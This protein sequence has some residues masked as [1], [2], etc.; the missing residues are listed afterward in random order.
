MLRSYLL[1]FVFA[2]A[3][4]AAP[5]SAQGWVNR[6]GPNSPAPRLSHAMCYDPV[7]GYVLMVG[8]KT[9]SPFSQWAGETWSWDGLVWTNRGAAPVPNFSASTY[10]NIASVWAAATHV[11]S[12]R[13]FAA[14]TA[15]SSA[16]SI[17]EWNGAVWSQVG[18]GVIGYHYT[19]IAMAS[20]PI[21]Q[22]T[23]LFSAADTGRVTVFDGVSWT[24]RIVTSL[25]YGVSRCSMAY[26]P[27]AGRIVLSAFGGPARFYEWD[28][29]GWAQR[30]PLALPPQGVACMSTDSA[31]QRVVFRDADYASVQVNHT[32]AYANGVCTQLT[33]PIEP[34]LR[35]SSAMAYDPIRGVHVMFGGAL[36]HSYNPMGDTWEFDLGPTASFTSFGTGCTGARGVPQLTAQPNSLPRIG[37][38]F[39]VRASNLPWTGPALMLLGLSD[40]IYGATPL[41][42]DLG[43]L[44]AP[45]CYLRI[46][47]DDL[48]P[49]QNILG[50]ATWSFTIPPVPGAVF[51]M[52]AVPFDATANGL[53]LTFSN[54]GRA[55]VGL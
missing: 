45:T 14:V 51:Y 4:L 23:V 44:N 29:F 8:G 49:I 9:Y 5:S 11:P 24:T 6:T 7:R 17:Y 28:G 25:P 16:C 46:S 50:T 52:Q 39:T 48:Q 22:E 40:A 12:G 3:F 10:S 35:A 55:V 20:D 53:G 19:D 1:A 30:L 34:T 15:L 31:R 33:T 13:A 54:G 37:Q 26:D 18:S 2:L 38:T 27:S 32:W 21:R 43:F 47:I 41:P 42:V 36:D